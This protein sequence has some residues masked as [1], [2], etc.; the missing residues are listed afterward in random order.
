MILFTSAASVVPFVSFGVLPTDYGAVL[1]LLGVAATAA[2]Q[3]AMAAAM[4]LMRRRSLVVLAMAALMGAAA[5]VAVG[6]ALLALRAAV[7]GGPGVLWRLHS[8]CE[9][10][11]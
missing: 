10:P 1:L 6:Q 4:R 9:S 3:L 5:S 11:D 8:V 2:G 7:D